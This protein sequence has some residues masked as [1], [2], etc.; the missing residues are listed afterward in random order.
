MPDQNR[1]WKRLKSFQLALI[2]GGLAGLIVVGLGYLR[3]M[4]DLDPTG[5]LLA[6]AAVMVGLTLVLAY[7]FDQISK[8]VSSFVGAVKGKGRGGGSKRGPQGDQ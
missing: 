3:I 1:A 7:V 6:G 8:S 4:G 2:V 5:A